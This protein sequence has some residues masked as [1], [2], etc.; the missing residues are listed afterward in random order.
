MELLGRDLK[1]WN[2]GAVAA[3]TGIIIGAF[4]LL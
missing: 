1:I 3:A 4:K 2:G